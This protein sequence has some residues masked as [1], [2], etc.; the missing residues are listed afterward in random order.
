M[1]R[2]GQFRK[3]DWDNA[4]ISRGDDHR[5][6]GW[7]GGPNAPGLRSMAP[8]Q[9]FRQAG[10]WAACC[11]VI[12]STAPAVLVAPLLRE[13]LIMAAFVLSMLGLLRGESLTLKA[14]NR[15]DVAL[16]LIAGAM[17]AA[18]FID[19]AAVAAYI[20]TLDTGSAASAAAAAS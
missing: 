5:P 19:H 16:L 18:L 11:L 12:A 1:N 9:V 6:G 20:E 15:Q 14:F 7:N 17:L 3:Q 10:I 8:A 2:N 13:L 4:P